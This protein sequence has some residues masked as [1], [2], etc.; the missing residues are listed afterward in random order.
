LLRPRELPPQGR[1]RRE[2]LALQAE[3]VD[4]LHDVEAD[5][6]R[7]AARRQHLVED[8]RRC[9]DALG[10]LNPRFRRHLPLPADVDA[11]PDG[12]KPLAGARLRE[13]IVTLLAGSGRT[14]TV[15]EINRL[16][17]AHG[18]RPAR[19]PSEAIPNALRTEV[20]RGRVKRVGRGRYE[21][22]AALSWT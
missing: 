15:P 14:M 1:V 22:L 3:T 11:V 20:R 18:L 5:L 9:R 21:A 16:L 2:L 13:A 19:A 6:Q 10:G 17:L 12:T 4:A 8:L 7:L